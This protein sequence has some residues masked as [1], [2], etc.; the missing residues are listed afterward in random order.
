[1][2]CGSLFDLSAK[3]LYV[4]KETE[5]YVR[6]ISRIFFGIY[7]LLL[8]YLMFFAEE[9]GRTMLEGDYRYNLMPFREISR[10]LKYHRQ[11]G[12]Q[13]V[14]WNLLGNII[15]FVPYGALLPAMR[16]KRMGF[17]KT[18]L[19][20]FELTLFIE[21][22]QLVLRVGS[23]DVGDMILNT[24]GG[25]IGYGIYHLVFQKRRKESYHEK[26]V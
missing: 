16:K 6:L 18:A 17:F 8:V 25:C 19:L 14:F 1:M 9:W 11:I 22:S 5:K 12:W 2:C 20:S 3:E 7:L 23:C 21:V 10:Y 13:R 26:T 15:G 4:K 24:L